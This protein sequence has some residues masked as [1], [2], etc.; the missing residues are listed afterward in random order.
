MGRDVRPL[1]HDVPNRPTDLLTPLEAL[2]PCLLTSPFAAP[3]RSSETA[4]DSETSRFL[5]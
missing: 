1:E 3:G 5:P 2:L 4:A